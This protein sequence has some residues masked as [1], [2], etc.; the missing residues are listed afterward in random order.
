MDENRRS[1]FKKLGA[2]AGAVVVAPALLAQE[3]DEAKKA[4]VADD[5][6]KVPEIAIPSTP[7]FEIIEWSTR[8]YTEYYE[9]SRTKTKTPTFI[10]KEGWMRVIN[11]STEFADRVMS[12]LIG[13]EPFAVALPDAHM[14]GSWCGDVLIT[15]AEYGASGMHEDIDL[16][17]QFFVKDKLEF[18]SE[19]QRIQR[20]N[21]KNT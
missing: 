18:I 16:S 5:I 20:D 19:L 7:D 8:N 11:F 3:I 21:R 6:L 4:M 13:R 12:G 14:D 10:A 15:Q 2:G 17:L 1:F 9:D